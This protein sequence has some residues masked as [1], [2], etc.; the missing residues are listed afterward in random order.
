M[1]DPRSEIAA[2]IQAFLAFFCLLAAYFV[3]RPARYQLGGAVGAVGA[4]V[5]PRFYAATY[6]VTLGLTPVFGGLA[7]RSEDRVPEALPL[8]RRRA[9][10]TI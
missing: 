8:S 10:P 3:L 4:V 2:S 6:V 1:A 7:A 5:R 9:Q